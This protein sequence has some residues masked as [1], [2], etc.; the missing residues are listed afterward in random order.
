MATT[1]TI[2]SRLSELTR[3][4]NS[5]NSTNEKKEIL[6]KY[7]DIKNVIRLIYNPLKPFNITSKKILKFAKENAQAKFKCVESDLCKMLTMFANSELTGHAAIKTALGLMQKFANYKD[8]ILMCIDKDLKMRLGIKQI[9]KVWPSLIPEFEVALGN[10]YEAKKHAKQ[11]K[12]GSKWYI[13]RKLDGVRCLCFVHGKKIDFFSRQGKEFLTLQTLAKDIV[14]NIAPKLQTIKEN[15]VEIFKD[16]FVLDGE[17]CIMDKQGTEDFKGIMKEIKRKNHDIKNVRYV[18]F[19]CLTHEEFENRTSDALF[20]TRLLRMNGLLSPH[21][22]VIP[23]RLYTQK[24]FDKQFKASGDLGWEGLILRKDATYKGKRSNDLLKVKQFF[25]EEYKVLDVVSGP[26]RIINPTTKLEETITTCV[27]VTI[28]HKGTPVSVGSGFSLQ[29]RQHFYKNPNS[30][31]G[32]TISVQFFE[33]TKSDQGTV[34]LRF[35]TFKGLYGKTR[36]F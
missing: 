32:K 23:Q 11:L 24:E 18:L 1:L 13:S 36:T 31:K 2:L 22:I 21:V 12:L 6:A 20:S 35:P 8:T 4:I 29:E 33:E 34:S 10:K 19:D 25:T 16:G 28:E 7:A 14:K 15:G 9:N 26:F 27:S 30:I 5:T 3:E 17:V